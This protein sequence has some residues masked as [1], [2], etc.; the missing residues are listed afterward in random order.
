VCQNTGFAYDHGDYA[1]EI[2]T[3]YIG[4]VGP[5]VKHLGLD[6]PAADKGA[7]SSGPNSGQIEVA[8]DNF[9]GPWADETDIRPTV[10]YLAGLRDDYEH[11]GRVVTQVLSRPNKALGA[12]GVKDLGACYKQLDSSVGHF[13]AATLIAST[14]AIQSS[15]KNDKT[16]LTVD[17]ALRVLEV[18]RD[19]LAGVIKGEL[20]AAAF[21]DKKISGVGT[22]TKACDALIS[23]ANKLAASS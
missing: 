17:A 14:K 21:H 4:L 1:A 5:G 10:L 2:N 23:T 20:E 16:F 3:N 11:D 19:K 8:Q 6:G 9:P 13:G 12:S 22:Q 15:A 7:T 18:A